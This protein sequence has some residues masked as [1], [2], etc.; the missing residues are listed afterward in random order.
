MIFKCLAALRLFLL[1]AQKLMQFQTV[2]H[3]KVVELLKGNLLR[4]LVIVSQRAFSDCQTLCQ[5]CIGNIM[6]TL[7][8]PDFAPDQLLKRDSPL[9]VLNLFHRNLLPFYFSEQPHIHLYTA[10]SDCMGRSGSARF[11]YLIRSMIGA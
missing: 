2:R 4:A 7:P 3:Q 6:Q 10:V 11:V 9:N 5:I 1:H 8:I